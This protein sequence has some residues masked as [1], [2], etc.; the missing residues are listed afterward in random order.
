MTDTV[1]GADGRE[2]KRALTSVFFESFVIDRTPNSATNAELVKLRKEVADLTT[3][4]AA[5]DSMLK[6]LTTAV[7]QQR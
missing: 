4:L 6:T 3:Q 1:L 5:L 2:H 7:Q